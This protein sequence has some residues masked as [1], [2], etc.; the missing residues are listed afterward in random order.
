MGNMPSAHTAAGISTVCVLSSKCRGDNY[1]FVIVLFVCGLLCAPPTDLCVFVLLGEGGLPL[2][3]TG[4]GLCLTM[5][6][7]ISTATM[8][9]RLSRS[10]PGNQ[11]NR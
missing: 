1:I 2:W 10:H 11:N 7:L 3:I 5:L 9:Y 6:L 8:V 4:T